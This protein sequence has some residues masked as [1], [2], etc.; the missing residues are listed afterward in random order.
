MRILFNPL[1]STL[2]SLTWME[3]VLKPIT[4]QMTEIEI[5]SGRR[6]RFDRIAIAANVVMYCIYCV[7]GKSAF[8]IYS[9]WRTHQ[10][11]TFTVDVSSSSTSTKWQNK[12]TQIKTEQRTLNNTVAHHIVLIS[13]VLGSIQLWT[14]LFHWLIC[15]DSLK[16]KRKLSIFD[17][18]TLWRNNKI[19]VKIY[20]VDSVAV[21]LTHHCHSARED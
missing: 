21:V 10:L 5:T 14:V 7:R 8:I 3:S 13:S 16:F 6:I 11:I 15:F 1:F 4:T 2:S 9:I 19:I 18:S 20:T 17:N 12:W